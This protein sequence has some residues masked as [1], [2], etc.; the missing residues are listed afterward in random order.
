M[1]WFYRWNRIIPV[2]PRGRNKDALRAARGVLAAGGVLGIFPEGG[3]S[4]DGKLMLGSKG[5]VSL[6]LTRNVQV[7][8]VGIIGGD[9]AFPSGAV[10]PWPRKIVVRFGE[11]IAAEELMEDGGDRKERL[12]LATMRIMQQIATLTGQTAREDQLRDKRA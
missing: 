7:V 1:G 5:A 2:A 11:P 12:T 10:L 9:R 4:R 8:P 6:G 3:L